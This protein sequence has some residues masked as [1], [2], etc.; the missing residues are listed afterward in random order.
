M[1]LTNTGSTQISH[2][3]ISINVFY[4]TVLDYPMASESII[5]ENIKS[6]CYLLWI[7]ETR[8][9]IMIMTNQ[10]QDHDCEGDITMFDIIEIIAQLYNSITLLLN[11]VKS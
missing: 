3:H 9:A 1:W 6:L 8:I 11:E 2:Y 4:H 5:D 10:H 7:F